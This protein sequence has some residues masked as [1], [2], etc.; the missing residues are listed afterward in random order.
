MT[1]WQGVKKIGDVDNFRGKNLDLSK[2]QG[3]RWN[4]DNPLTHFCTVPHLLVSP[5]FYHHFLYYDSIKTTLFPL[6]IVW[7]PFFYYMCFPDKKGT[8]S[9]EGGETTVG[10]VTE[11]FYPPSTR[12]PTC[13]LTPSLGGQSMSLRIGDN[14]SGIKWENNGLSNYRP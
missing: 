11:G 7:G 8:L 9:V 14:L 10:S 6:T 4:G 1:L 2:C 3:T 12:E 13:Y 5:T